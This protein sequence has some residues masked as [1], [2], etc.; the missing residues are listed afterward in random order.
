MVLFPD[1][2]APKQ[3]NKKTSLFFSSY[4]D[5]NHII[6]KKFMQISMKLVDAGLEV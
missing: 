2:P 5:I 6:M 4:M 3:F 1:S